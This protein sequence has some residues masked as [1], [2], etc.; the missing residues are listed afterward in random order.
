MLKRRSPSS[1]GFN[2]TC[3]TVTALP[4][5]IS[6]LPHQTYWLDKVIGQP[7]IFPLNRPWNW[8]CQLQYYYLSGMKAQQQDDWLFSSSVIQTHLY[9]DHG[10]TTRFSPSFLTTFFLLQAEES[11]VSPFGNSPPELFSKARRGE[12]WHLKAGHCGWARG[13]REPKRRVIF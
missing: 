10:Q 2:K 7:A 5:F 9:Y 13:K 11:E 3:R 4:L 6:I 1:S 8:L 12:I